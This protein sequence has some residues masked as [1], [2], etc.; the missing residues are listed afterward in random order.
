[1]LIAYDAQ[2]IYVTFNSTLKL[3]GVEQIPPMSE[4]LVIASL[5][6]KLRQKQNLLIC[7]NLHGRFS[8]SVTGGHT[9]ISADSSTTE[10]PVLLTNTSGHLVKLTPNLIVGHVVTIPD[11]Q[12]IQVSNKQKPTSGCQ[13]PKPPVQ[14]IKHLQG[15]QKILK[16]TTTKETCSLNRE[17]NCMNDQCLPLV[18][19][20]T[21]NSFIIP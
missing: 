20:V 19:I 9:L 21:K 15:P 2:G 12:I 17:T 10:Y 8:E 6:C 13:F 14:G 3:K 5:D 16:C 1:M 4:K 18:K 7:G 11:N